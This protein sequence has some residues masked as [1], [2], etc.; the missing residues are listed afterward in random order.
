MLFGGSSWGQRQQTVG[1]LALSFGCG[2][3]VGTGLRVIWVEGPPA[4]HEGCKCV[5]FPS[6]H[7]CGGSLFSARGETLFAPLDC[8]GTKEVVP[9]TWVSGGCLKK[10]KTFTG[11]T[12]RFPCFS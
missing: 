11:Q 10:K 5:V 12:K 8:N 9:G 4:D 3:G 7:Y 1:Q 6:S 2:A